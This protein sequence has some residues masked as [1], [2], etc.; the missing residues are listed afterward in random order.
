MRHTDKDVDEAARRYERV[1][2][3]LDP[4]TAE[5]DNTEDLRAIADASSTLHDDEARVREAV[6]VARARGRSWNEIAV[7]LGVSR[8]AARQKY[9]N[10]VA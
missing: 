3:E 9:A 4:E 1:T 5:V 2:D 10:K 6:G 7:A 8:Q